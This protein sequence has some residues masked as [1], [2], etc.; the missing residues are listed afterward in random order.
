MIGDLRARVG[1]YRALES[2]DD[3][4]GFLTTWPLYKA[5]WASVKLLAPRQAFDNG[6]AE[7]TAH[8][9]VIIRFQD[10]FPERARLIWGERKLRVVAASD[11]DGRRERLHLICEEEIQ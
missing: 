8:Y 3:M 1:V 9:R 10:G 4:G 5:V 6:R 2:P 7:I 11:P